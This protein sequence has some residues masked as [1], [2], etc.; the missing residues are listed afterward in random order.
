MKYLVITGNVGITLLPMT[1]LLFWTLRI[2]SSS[3]LSSLLFI[4]ISWVF[5]YENKPSV[6][7][8]PWFRCLIARALGK[9]NVWGP[10]V[11]FLCSMKLESA[12]PANQLKEKA[13][14]PLRTSWISQKSVC[15]VWWSYNLVILIQTFRMFSLR[16][17]A[18]RALFTWRTAR[19]KDHRLFYRSYPQIN[20][21]GKSCHVVC[22]PVE[23]LLIFLFPSEFYG[24][25]HQLCFHNNVNKE[26]RGEGRWPVRPQHVFM[27]LC[28]LLTVNHASSRLELL[29]A[30]RIMG[31]K[32]LP[33]AQSATEMKCVVH[34]GS[35]WC[36]L[37]CRESGVI[38]DDGTAGDF[39][40]T[41]DGK[42]KK[43]NKNKHA[44][45]LIGFVFLRR[46]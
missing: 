4:V 9:Y 27:F 42:V 31:E 38:E 12:C 17:S 8:F 34:N 46:L 30:L 20:E 23:S 36:S 41:A 22:L 7:G 19:A 26:P 15:H 1:Q 6:W 24:Q 25:F 32:A 39:G 44:D 40:F 37:F 13:H 33:S 29:G 16:E 21:V 11:M 28:V 2:P 45:W 3:I 35:V 14:K 5:L 18:F 43:H 10:C